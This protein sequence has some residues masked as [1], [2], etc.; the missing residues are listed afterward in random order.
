MRALSLGQ[1]AAQNQAENGFANQRMG[2]AN[3]EFQN[4]VTQQTI[5]NEMA[6]S[7]FDFDRQQWDAGAPMRDINQQI[8]LS[9]IQES[10]DEQAARAAAAAYLQSNGMGGAENV[11]PRILKIV[12]E[13]KQSQALANMAAMPAD[14]MGPPDPSKYAM[15]QNLP[16]DLAAGLVRQQMAEGAKGRLLAKAMQDVQRLHNA[17][18]QAGMPAKEIPAAIF[19][20]IAHY[21][22]DVRSEAVMSEF[23]IGAASAYTTKAGGYSPAETQN[24]VGTGVLTPEGKAQLDALRGDPIAARDLMRQAHA[25][26]KAVHYDPNT[27]ADYQ[28]A[29]AERKATYAAYENAM[30]LAGGVSDETTKQAFQAHQVAIQK[31]AQIKQKNSKQFYAQ[32]AAQVFQ[33]KFGHPYDFN[34]PQDTQAMLEIMRGLQSQR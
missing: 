20:T 11:D 7:R 22:D 9:R 2:L 30:K 1:Q 15:Y 25:T 27:D 10:R 5:D 4:R 3:Q 14:G 16:P 32:Q 31:A 13:S 12:D 19:N 33:Q 23:G 34:N 8:G 26:P 6:R 29:E 21:P 24:M 18:I 28:Q 17:A